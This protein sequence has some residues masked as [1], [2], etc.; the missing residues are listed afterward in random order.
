MSVSKW[1]AA[2]FLFFISLSSFA[3]ATCDVVSQ[4]TLTN[5]I[6]ACDKNKWN[7]CILKILICESGR[8]QSL[9]SSLDI[10]GFLS[11]SKNSKYK[12]DVNYIKFVD[13]END[14]GIFRVAVGYSIIASQSN[15]EVDANGS[16]NGIGIEA[17][18]SKGDAEIRLDVF[19]VHS[20]NASEI[21]Q[22]IPSSIDVDD[23]AIR[24]ILDSFGK[25]VKKQVALVG[26]GSDTSN[27]TL[28][29][30][31][32]KVLVRKKEDTDK[33]QYLRKSIDL[34]TK[35]AATTTGS[36]GCA[37]KFPN[38]T[39]VF[40]N[41]D[42]ALG[43]S[44]SP[45][46]GTAKANGDDRLV[47]Q[48]YRRY[49]YVLAGSA[50]AI[51]GSGAALYI[52]AAGLDASVDSLM[53]AL[54]SIKYSR[55]GT[56]VQFDYFGGSSPA[57]LMADVIASE[58]IGTATYFTDMSDRFKQVMANINDGKGVPTKIVMGADADTSARTE[59]GPTSNLSEGKP[60]G[61]GL[62]AEIIKLG[63]GKS[64]PAAAPKV[65]QLRLY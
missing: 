43:A 48:S 46:A 20:N 13:V 52:R 18:P 40:R 26:D 17:K 58:A 44:V 30:Q 37:E 35:I 64:K 61:G 3:E 15:A 34:Q 19:G 8:A 38:A 32:V 50:T 42:K 9:A 16:V 6:T 54:F 24:K 31:V 57:F 23:K 36:A 49:R 1:L 28:C 27:M 7:A 45:A 5:S 63:S 53:S 41:T 47:T 59:D 62:T 39:L 29:P 55:K 2:V 12:E 25:A 21:Y 11:S 33:D 10:S 51:E 56:G 60:G 65:Q 22:T 4:T 14:D